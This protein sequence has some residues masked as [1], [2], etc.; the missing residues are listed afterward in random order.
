MTPNNFEQDFEE[1]RG[2]N[3]DG[4]EK[5]PG[6]YVRTDESELPQ[7]LD[8]LWS[9]PK[10]HHKEDRSPIIPFL[11]GIAVGAV[12]SAA[13]FFLFI[14]QPDR[15]SVQENA[16]TLPVTDTL[17]QDVPTL[18]DDNIQGGDSSSDSSKKP[19]VRIDSKRYTVK[20][21]DTLGSIAEQAYGSSSLEYIEKIQR[22]NN[23]DNPNQL[24]LDQVLIIP[25]KRY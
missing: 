24:K 17:Q 20:S 4:Q 21:G 12:L 3:P 19:V 2:S 25:P 13:F 1:K 9:G 23:L 16:I 11:F 8:M 5:A 18:G 6:V 22:A 10:A 7:E 14:L 15:V